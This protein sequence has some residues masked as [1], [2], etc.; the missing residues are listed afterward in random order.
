[1]FQWSLFGNYSS[2]RLSISVAF[3]LGYLGRQSVHIEYNGF[4]AW[5]SFPVL[6]HQVHSFFKSCL[7]LF[8]EITINSLI[9]HCSLSSIPM[10]VWLLHICM[11]LCPGSL[12]CWHYKGQWMFISC[13]GSQTFQ[14]KAVTW[15]A[16]IKWTAVAG[17]C[18]QLQ[19]DPTSLWLW[20]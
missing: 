7:K 12:F 17:I 6:T 13:T 19:R 5:I 15:S 8:H 18:L 4:Y 11:Y 14:A 16:E 20:A 3:I 9:L 2:K 10:P 1:M